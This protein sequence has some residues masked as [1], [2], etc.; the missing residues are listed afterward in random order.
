M[1]DTR[2][3][4]ALAVLVLATS[5]GQ[6]RQAAVPEVSGA[7]G[8]RPTIQIPDGEPAR[9]PQVTVLSTGGGPRT[10]PG[11][12]VLADI[13]I[14]QWAGNRAYLNTYDTNRPATVLLDAAQLSDAWR[15]ALA[16]RPAGSR[17]MLVSPAARA[18]GQNGPL[19]GVDPAATLV[20]VF[21]ILGGYPR[22]ARLVGQPLSALPPDL[23]PAGQARTLIGGS[24]AEVRQ[25]AKVV[26]QYVGARWPSRKVFDSSQAR[27]GPG[28]FVLK[29]GAVPPGWVEGLAGQ[30]VGSRVAVS[31]RAP[32]G[33]STA[34]G[35]RA[36]AGSL[37]Y[38]VDILAAH[39]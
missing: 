9:A 19:V 33:T 23:R 28:A 13:E 34:G 12:V 39:Q 6:V 31:A 21:D 14:R 18:S 27:G 25:G 36:P 30:R 16:D 38:V 3:A 1:T 10:R 20:L 22:D 37:L 24:G 17:V 11:D 29:P 15:A 26:V 5:C 35:V 7:F 2:R 8:V 4:A 32:A